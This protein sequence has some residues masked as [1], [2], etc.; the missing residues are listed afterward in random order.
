[1]VETKNTKVFCNTETPE[2]WQLRKLKEILLE[3]RL[4]GNYENA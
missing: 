4:G 2:G 3:G 1:M